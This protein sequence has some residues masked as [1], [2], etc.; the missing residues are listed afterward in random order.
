MIA[1]NKPDLKSVA[2]WS[3]PYNKNTMDWKDVYAA[4]IFFV[5]INSK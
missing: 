3:Q 5:L 4:S 2:V 1:V